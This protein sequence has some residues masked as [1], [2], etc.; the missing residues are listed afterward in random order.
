MEAASIC[1]ND[2]IC[3]VWYD[4]FIYLLSLYVLSIVDVMYGSVVTIKQYRTGGAY[5]HSHWHLYPEG[6]GARQQQ[7]CLLQSL[8]LRL[9]NE[10][11]SGRWHRIDTRMLNTHGKLGGKVLLG[12]FPAV[13]QGAHLVI[14]ES[15]I[16]LS[17]SYNYKENI[18]LK[19]YKWMYRCN[20]TQTHNQ[21]PE[22]K[23]FSLQWFIV[24]IPFVT[25]S[26]TFG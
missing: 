11:Q 14:T 5:L 20:H 6:V 3:Y 12:T 24:S 22:F 2:K 23:T 10:S 7:V 8:I 17:F 1:A 25:L 15:W 16:C 21:T 4:S 18:P 26:I 19:N 9:R 13:K